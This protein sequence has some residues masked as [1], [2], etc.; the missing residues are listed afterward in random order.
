MIFRFWLVLIGLMMPVFGWASEA[1]RIS[2]FAGE[3]DRV[4]SVVKFAAPGLGAGVYVLSGEGRKVVMQVDG[5]GLAVMVEPELAKGSSRTYEV[6]PA[7]MAESR[8]L[9]KVSDDGELLSFVGEGGSLLKYQMKASQ[10]PQGIASIFS[11]GAHLHPV[12]SPS[13]KV[14]TGDYPEDHPHHRGI[15][16]SWTKT[17]YEG[18][19]P[20]FW[21]MGKDKSGKLTGEVRFAELQKQWGGVV[22][23]GFVGVHHHV[24]HTS[25]V[26]KVVLSEV[27]KVRVYAAMKQP[28]A[29]HVFDLVSA[30]QLVGNEPLKLP[31]YHYGGL[32]VRGAREWDGVGAVQML[33]SNGDGREEGDASKAKWVYLGGDVR[34]GKSGLVV[35]IHPSNFRFPQPLRL[36]PK[37][38]QLSVAPSVDGDWEIG[39]VGS[40]V[41]RYRFVVLDGEVK[42]EVLEKLWL[43]YAQPVVVKVEN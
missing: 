6:S 1:V 12:F 33:T 16:M 18:R 5:E 26:E 14:V 10:V 38:P 13:G 23:G 20:D 22:S 11:H 27:W 32:G 15:W 8:E 24:D 19:A 21:N 28:L 29:M 25:G 9:V 3:L 42:R 39:G 31:K 37:N 7:S 2:V 36:N 4:N 30:Q 17:S 35:L 43:D 41:S 40:Y 34:G